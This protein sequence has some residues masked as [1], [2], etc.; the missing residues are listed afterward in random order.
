MCLPTPTFLWHTIDSLMGCWSPLAFAI[1]LECNLCIRNWMGNQPTIYDSNVLELTQSN[2]LM[3]FQLVWLEYGFNEKFIFPVAFIFH[4][5]FICKNVSNLSYRIRFLLITRRNWSTCLSF[6]TC[7]LFRL[8]FYFCLPFC[9]ITHS[10]LDF[11]CQQFYGCKLRTYANMLSFAHSVS[12]VAMILLLHLLVFT[13]YV[14]LVF[15]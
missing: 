7:G 5:Y 8:S 12:V 10:F 14:A 2:S 6:S 11:L 9:G 1:A 3:V 13:L 15:V 4:R